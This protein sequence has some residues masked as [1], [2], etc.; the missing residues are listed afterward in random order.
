MFILLE[1]IQDPPDIIHGNVLLDE[2]LQQIGHLRPQVH[3]KAYEPV[4]FCQ[5]KRFS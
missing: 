4:R 2:L 1:S 5:V 3:E